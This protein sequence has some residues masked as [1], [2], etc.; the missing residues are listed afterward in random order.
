MGTAEGANAEDR[1]AY[2]CM[3][4]ELVVTRLIM[5][6]RSCRVVVGTR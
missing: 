4:V 3:N 1:Y 2:L 5:T 6:I